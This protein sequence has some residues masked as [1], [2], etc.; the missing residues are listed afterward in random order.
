MDSGGWGVGL[1]R[2][3][4]GEQRCLLA[5]NLAWMVPGAMPRAIIGRPY[6]AE[7]LEL[8]V[9]DG[10]EGGGFLVFCDAAFEEVLLFFDVHHF[11]E[12]GKGIG[13]RFV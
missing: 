2:R 11:G 1:R 4:L 7:E 8:V 9:V 13:D 3:L 12:P 6:R 5:R 10:G